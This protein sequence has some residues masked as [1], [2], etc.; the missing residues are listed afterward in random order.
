MSDFAGMQPGGWGW[1]RKGERS[2]QTS[3]VSCPFKVR[4]GRTAQKVAP[5]VHL[6]LSQS[7][8][9]VTR[10]AELWWIYS[11]ALLNHT[12]LAWPE[13]R[14]EAAG[15]QPQKSSQRCS[16]LRAHVK[17]KSC[18]RWWHPHSC[19]LWPCYALLLTWAWRIF[20]YQYVNKH[21]HAYI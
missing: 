16:Y 8:S 4:W 17:P 11:V 5:E 15:L 3:P 13:S 9:W 14:R 12:G 7:V 10:I 21:T 19:A 20:C 1:G 18:L 6:H 2:G